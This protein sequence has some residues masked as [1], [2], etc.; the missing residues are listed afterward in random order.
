MDRATVEWLRSAQLA[1]LRAVDR[2]VAAIVDALA[3]TG[4]LDDALLVFTSDNG[5]AWG[6][7]RW[8]KKEV[9]YEEAIRVPLVIR[10]GDGARGATSDA[11]AANVDLAPTVLA[12]AGVAAPPG[13]G[14]SLTP[15]LRDPAATVRDEVVLEHMEGT[16]PVPTYCGIR[17][18]DL[19]LVRYATGEEE[20]FDLRADPDELRNVAATDPRRDAL[21]TRLDAGCR[22]RPPGWFDGRGGP[23]AAAVVALALWLGWR[24]RRQSTVI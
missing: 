14:V 6:E 11:L 2:Q 10:W 22:P 12:A 21:A 16:N 23:A 9:P 7:H 3:D 13:D 19:K 15:V 20:L 4:R 24:S 8:M 18:A 17:T 5:L 1:S